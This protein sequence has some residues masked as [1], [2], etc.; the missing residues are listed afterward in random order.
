LPLMP[1]FIATGRRRATRI[2]AERARG[3]SSTSRRMA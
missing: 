3:F 2:T 1:P